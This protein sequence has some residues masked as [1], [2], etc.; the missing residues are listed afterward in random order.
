MTKKSTK[1]MIVFT[2][3]RRKSG[4]TMAQL[5]KATGWQPHSLRAALSRLRHSGIAIN[6]SDNA[7]GVSVYRLTPEDEV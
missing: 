5:V 1:S 7:K 4:T 3:L 6:R 2:I